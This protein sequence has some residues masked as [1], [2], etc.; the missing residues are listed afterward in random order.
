MHTLFA[1]AWLRDR[2]GIE[3]LARQVPRRVTMSPT[4]ITDVA[5]AALVLTAPSLA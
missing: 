5:Q 2:C 3:R 4:G 1:L